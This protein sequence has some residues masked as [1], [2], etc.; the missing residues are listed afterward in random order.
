MRPTCLKMYAEAYLE[1]S[2]TYMMELICK[3]PKKAL[4]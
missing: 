2:Q 4:L 1:P 3:N